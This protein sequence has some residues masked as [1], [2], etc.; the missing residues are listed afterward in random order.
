HS[1]VGGL[2][3]AV[4]DAVCKESPVPEKKIGRQDVFGESG[5]AKELVQKYQLDEMGIDRQVLEFV[6]RN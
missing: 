1:V 4:C 5:P 6:K 2:G 3:S